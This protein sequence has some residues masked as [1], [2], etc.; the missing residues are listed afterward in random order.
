M[1]NMKSVAPET[2][3]AQEEPES[4]QRARKRD[5]PSK[6]KKTEGNVFPLARFVIGFKVQRALLV[7]CVG[8]PHKSW[9]DEQRTWSE[10]SRHERCLNLSR[11]SQ[12]GLDVGSHV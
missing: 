12:M 6:D 3:Q 10:Q 7:S 8:R 11:R 9:C 1:R 4:N 2:N 5:E